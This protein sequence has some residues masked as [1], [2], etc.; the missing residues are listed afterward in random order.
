MNGQGK[1]LQQLIGKF[2]DQLFWE[3]MRPIDIVSSG[4]Q[5]GK[6]ER[7]KVRFH[8]ELCPRLGGSIRVSGFQDMFFRHGVGFEIFTFP[9]DLISRDMDESAKS[10]THLGR[11]EEDVGSINVGLSKRKGVAKRVVDVRL[12]CKVHNGVDSFFP[13]HIGNQVR[14][15][16]VTLDEFE[17][18]QVKQLFQVCQTGAVIEIVVHYDVVVRVLLAEQNGDM[19][20]NETGATGHHNVLGPIQNLLFGRHLGFD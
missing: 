11:L 7:A 5:A 18:W 15:R 14:R 10:G 19:R 9:V 4:D 1:I 8:Q 12:S 20:S 6:L 16:N 13:E 17:V 2:R 3:L